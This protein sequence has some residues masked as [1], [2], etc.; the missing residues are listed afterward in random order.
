MS[1]TKFFLPVAFIG[2][3][4]GCFP[5]IPDQ[6]AFGVVNG[7]ESDG[8]ITCSGGLRATFEAG[9]LEIESSRVAPLDEYQDTIRNLPSDV[10][11][12]T[13]VKIEAWCY[14]ANDPETTGYVRIEQTWQANATN[15]VSVYPRTSEASICARAVEKR[16]S[17]PCVRS[18]LLEDE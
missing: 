5:E 2:L 16:G 1:I 9:S 3:L 14:D 6:L 18:S 12:G 8:N 4:A 11:V 15:N 7:R 10:G 17:A 13:S